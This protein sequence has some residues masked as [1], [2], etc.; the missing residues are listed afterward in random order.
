MSQRRQ[1]TE[2][3]DDS[4][5]IVTCAGRGGAALDPKRVEPRK[6]RGSEGK[7]PSHHE[8]SFDPHPPTLPQRRSAASPLRSCYH[9]TPMHMMCDVMF[10]VGGRRWPAHIS[11]GIVR[12]PMPSS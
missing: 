2:P 5:T 8:E 11:G 3:S 6:I 4:W 12:M 1:S 10:R 9:R 7:K